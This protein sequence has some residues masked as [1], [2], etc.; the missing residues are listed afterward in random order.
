[1]ARHIRIQKGT[2]TTTHDQVMN[3]SSLNAININC[4][5]FTEQNSS[6]S[7]PRSFFKDQIQTAIESND[8][9]IKGMNAKI[10]RCLP[11]SSLSHTNSSNMRS[12]N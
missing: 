11:D 3:R 5:I 9:K 2:K 10:Q 4:K 6:N 1:M 8:I 12:S 7:K